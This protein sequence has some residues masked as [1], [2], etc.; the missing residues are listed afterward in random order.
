MVDSTGLVRRLGAAV[1]GSV[2]LLAAGASHAAV[3][4]FQGDLAGFNAAAGSPP[5]TI[6]FES[7]SG[8]IAGSTH[9]GV[10]FSSPDGNTLE[11]VDGNATFTNPA[12]FTGIIDA[13]TNKLFPTSGIKVL[14]PGGLELA[15]GPDVRERDG[16]QLD[17]AT[18]FSAFGLDVLFQ[19]YDC[20][21]FTTFTAY[22]AALQVVASGGLIG[23]GGGGG[24]PGG[25]LFVGLVSD[26][27]LTDISRL[28]FSETDGNNAFPDSNIGYDT[29]RFNGPACAC[30]IPEP[31]T[32]AM[33]ILGFGFAGAALRR[34][35]TIA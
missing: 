12:S 2:L 6:D 17:F 28:V 31:T 19:S 22:N 15:P 3:S 35:A 11:V 23:N 21:T 30:G 10:T 27:A 1:A 5:V 34:R 32:W 8:D 4:V 24:N 7:L 20:C 25:A 33:M 13:T 18:P 26:S 14:S 16:L 29:L 9:S